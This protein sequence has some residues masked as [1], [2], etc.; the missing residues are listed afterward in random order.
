M[1]LPTDTRYFSPRPSGRESA[2]ANLQPARII[3]AAAGDPGPH[4]TPALPA[5]PEIIRERD[6]T[7]EISAPRAWRILARG[8]SAYR[9]ALADPPE[10]TPAVADSWRYLADGCWSIW[11]KARREIEI[12]VVPEPEPYP[13]PAEM[14]ADIRRGRF[15]V[16]AANCEHPIWLEGDNVAFR[17]AHDLYGHAVSG[18]DFGWRG[19]MLAC[20][21]HAPLLDSRALPALACECIAQNGYAIASGGFGPQVCSDSPAIRELPRLLG[22]RGIW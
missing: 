6:R 20:S 13:G 12:T 18:G 16:S 3:R 14:L 21:T 4:L 5:P 2:P 9:A 8:A 15:K 17:I 10:I 7:A 19:E 11:D 22:W 1:N